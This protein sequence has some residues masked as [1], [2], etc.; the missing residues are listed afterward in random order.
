MELQSSILNKYHTLLMLDD[1][2]DV[3]KEWLIR[4]NKQAKGLSTVHFHILS[5]LQ[6]HP[7]ATAKAI[8]EEL[9]VLRGTL[10][11]R[12]FFLIQRHLIIVNTNPKDGRSK[13]YLLTEPGYKLAQSHNNLLQQKNRQ[14][15]SC[16]QNFSTQQLQTINIFLAEFVTA[17]TK[18][19]Y[20]K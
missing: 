2:D 9:Q 15:E 5:Y 12:L 11:K 7:N 17:E 18:I 3:E 6:R 1:N 13:C 19:T 20:P 8:S 10:S 16:L 4:Q 14:L